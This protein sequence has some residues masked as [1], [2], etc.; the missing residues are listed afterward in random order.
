MKVE[1]DINAS[2]NIESDRM[3]CHTSVNVCEDLH[4]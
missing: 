2:Y 4:N 1:T 3:I